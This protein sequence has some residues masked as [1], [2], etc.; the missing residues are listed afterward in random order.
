M[1]CG[2]ATTK[3]VNTIEQSSP[4]LTAKL[5]ELI[6]VMKGKEEVNIN[7]ITTE[8]TSDVNFIAR[9][10]YNPNWKIIV[11]VLNFLILIMEEHQIIL[12]VLMVAIEIL[13][14]KPSKVLFLARL[15]RIKKPRIS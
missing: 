3:R 11:M 2:K 4:E 7:S 14:K 12:V 6:S 9:N 8:E 5:D 15:S 10:S 1:A 13:L